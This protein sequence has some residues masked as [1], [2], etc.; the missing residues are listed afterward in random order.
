[1]VRI[2]A[3]ALVGDM[4]GA[5]ASATVA[6]ARK[7]DAGKLAKAGAG[8]ASTAAMAAAKAS[9][10]NAG[11]IFKKGAK[12][13]GKGV[14][15]TMENAGSAL[16]K[17][18]KKQGGE[19]LSSM[20]KGLKKS[21]DLMSWAG[22]KGG[23]MKKVAGEALDTVSSKWKKLDP[24]TQKRLGKAGFTVASIAALGLIFGT[25]DP[26][27]IAKEALKRAGKTLQSGL[28]GLLEG[29]GFD[30]AMVDKMKMGIYIVIALIV[31]GIIAKVIRK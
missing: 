31:L 15:G 29:M 5:V 16:L 28:G 2:R 7:M 8:G 17:G 11:D 13:L 22:K 19:A 21:S 14:K 30:D 10:K 20:Q 23:D 24:K 18:T 27:K 12:K 4:T 1:M 9:A 3:G 6:A 25:L 26:E